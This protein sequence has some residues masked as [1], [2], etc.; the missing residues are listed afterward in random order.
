MRFHYFTTNQFLP[1]V[2]SSIILICSIF[3]FCNNKT[4]TSLILLFVGSLV[5]G[6]FIANLDPF[7]ILWD[8]Q[9]HALV[10]KN[11]IAN[12]LKPTIYSTPLLEYD[13]KNWTAN[14]IWLHKQPLF[15]WQIALSLKLFGINTLAVRIP[16][17]LLHAILAL[18][19]FRIGKISNSE[20]VGYYG[21]LF[22]TVAYYPLE[23]VAARF[24][25]DHNDLSFLFYITASFWAWFEYQHS[26]NKY[27]LIL[28]GL[29]SACAI[30]VKWLVGLLIYVVWILIIGISNR[31]HL[32]K[33]KYY[34][35]IIASISITFLI[36]IPWQIYI[37]IK[38]P[39]ESNFEYA[40]NTKH[41]FEALENHEG[42]IWF[43]LNAF[44]NIY[45]SGDALPFIYLIGLG[46][47]L[48]NIK[49]NIFR[50][51]V[52]FAIAITYTFYSIASTKMTSYCVIVSPFVFLGLASLF[53][54]ATNFLKSK[55]NYNKFE[56][57]FRPLV[58]IIICTFLL[59][60]TKI[61]NYHTDWKPHDNYNRTL[62]INRMDFISKLKAQLGNEKFV[63]FNVNEK[64]NEHIPI[65][66]YTD[67]IAYDFIPTEKQIQIIE[68]NNYKIAIVDK[69]SLPNY[70]ISK[71][72]IIKIKL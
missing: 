36:F 14:H 38:F 2:I 51:A 58:L 67:Y 29:F 43:H 40:F 47:Y 45:G 63:V 11:L 13:Y 24:S 70:I 57:I 1:L 12:P 21:A 9:Y 64:L 48:K 66:F 68:S 65:M 34:Y 39:L 23:L 42:T 5:L 8:E 46:I 69:S 35:P 60:L 4:K 30:L 26:K 31:S 28:I 54:S 56:F 55:I 25:T 6:L 53:D 32:V 27:Y 19:I 61:Q 22:F 10:A 17:I 20:R 37:L 71:P 52:V 49:L 15:L 41:F 18:M 62:E 16:S 72:S 3:Y 7:L 50:Y 33:I 44:K 59:N